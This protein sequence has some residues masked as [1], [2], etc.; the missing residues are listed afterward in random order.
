MTL[1]GRTA[2]VTG[3]VQGIGE[4]IARTLHA[5]GAAVVLADLHAEQARST[6]ESIDPAGGRTW[7]SELDVRS[8]AAFAA[9]FEEADCPDLRSVV[10]VCNIVRETELG[11]LRLWKYLKIQARAGRQLF[12]GNE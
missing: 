1:A 3:A 9:V 4:A 11:G 2:V 7:A 8:R 5:D 12:C 6:A 10:N